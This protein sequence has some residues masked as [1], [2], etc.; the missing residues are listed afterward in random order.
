MQIFNVT[1]ILA[2][3]MDAIYARLVA[4]L[5]LRTQIPLNYLALPDWAAREQLFNTGNATLGMMCGL[6][7]THKSA[8]FDLLAAPI[9]AAA[10]YHN[11][12]VYFSDV[13][14]RAD[15]PIHHFADLRGKRWAFNERVSFSGHA[16]VCAHLHQMGETHA[17]FGSAIAVGSHANAIRAVLAGE[18]AAAAID[19]TVLERAKVLDP[20]L[21]GQLRH[22]ATLGPSP[23]PPIVIQKNAPP[24]IKQQLSEALL[25]MHTDV[26]GRE[27]LAEA[28]IARFVAVHDADYD[29][30]RQKAATTRWVT[31]SPAERERDFAHPQHTAHDLEALEYMRQTLLTN[32]PNVNEIDTYFFA[33]NDQPAHRVVVIDPQAL[34]SRQA[35]AVVGFFGQRNWQCPD[36]VVTAIN[37]IDVELVQGLFRFAYAV[38]YSSMKLPDGNWGNLI[39][40]KDFEGIEKWREVQPHPYATD[41]LSP[42]FYDSVRLH[43]G[44]MSHGLISPITLI[45]L[46]LYDFR[47]QR[48]G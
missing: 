36:S 31:L 9:M 2:G 13:I 11:Q 6:I 32:M 28:G 29:D 15:S 43:R 40:L 7:Y 48:T 17:Y 4:S 41:V 35:L 20:N 16:I 33:L 21:V 34:K 30:I 18:A 42:Y 10:R 5:S 24:T 46:K 19:S 8:Q 27:L 47:D 37:K 22:V 44:T 38:S 3:N 23:I 25:T 12:P 14:V 1:S 45:G 26:D 39:V